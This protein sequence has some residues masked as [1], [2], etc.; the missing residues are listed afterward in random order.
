MVKNIIIGILVVLLCA[1]GALIVLDWRGAE[2]R[3][4]EEGPQVEAGDEEPRVEESEVAEAE[5]EEA[6]QVRL[7]GV[8][9]SVDDP[10]SVITFEANG[11]VTDTYGGGV[12]VE[13][14]TY[15]L[16][17]SRSALPEDLGVT[18]EGPFLRQTFGE[19]DYYYEVSEL[20]ESVLELIHLSGRGNVLRYERL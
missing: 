4:S 20:S 15:Q 18:S 9:Q 13:T 14:G 7:V 10:Q 1:A 12:L 8:W 19:E 3:T 17:E 5:D 2:V 6:P 11:E 16:F